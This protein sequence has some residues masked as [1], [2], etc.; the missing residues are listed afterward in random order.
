MFNLVRFGFQSKSLRADKK[1]DKLRGLL[2]FLHDLVFLNIICLFFN[3]INSIVQLL[4]SEKLNGD[5]YAAWKLN[6]NTILVVG[7]LRFLLTEEFP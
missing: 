5:H 4:A 1:N 3:M 7:D 6:L 2:W